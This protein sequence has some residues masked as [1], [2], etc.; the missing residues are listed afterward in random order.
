MLAGLIILLLTLSAIVKPPKA[1]SLENFENGIQS[2]YAS[3]EGYAN[4]CGSIFRAKNAVAL[5]KEIPEEYYN[6]ISEDGYIPS[7]PVIIPIYGYMSE[8]GIHPA[9]FKFYGKESVNKNIPESLI[10]RTLY[11]NAIPV[12]WY[13]SKNINEKDYEALQNLG[14]NAEGR[15]IIMPW[16]EY[17]NDPLPRDRTIGF[18][19]FGM[20]QSCK[21]FDIEVLNQFIDF[22]ANHSFEDKPIKPEIAELSLPELL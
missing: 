2:F 20:S 10:I 4:G 8:R 12:I 11:D 14:K 1:F 9:Q 16:L 3:P 22:A 6:I 13:N 17:D 5:S 18:S 19:V 7:P 15:L 21:T